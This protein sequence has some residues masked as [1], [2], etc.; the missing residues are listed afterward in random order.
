M[1]GGKNKTK[2]G[3]TIVELMIAIAIF[4]IVLT[5]FVQLFSSAIYSQR[6]SL[7]NSYLLGNASFL[8][9]FLARDL[10]M[11]QKD[12]S[13]F[14]LQPKENFEISA[15]GKQIKF[16]NYDQKC[17]IIYIRGDR[18]IT[19]IGGID[20]N[21]IPS[22]IAAKNLKFFVSGESQNDL[23]QPKVTFTV[24]L[25][26]KRNPKKS[27]TVQSSISQRELDVKR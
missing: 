3:F 20:Y 16:L 27:I 5:G 8:M 26:T 13:G 2:R 14:C 24:N 10:R 18:I 4:A 9:E 1:I 12:D 6:E 25:S 21:L 19:N 22:N 15:D 23:L 11:A 7:N 17:Q